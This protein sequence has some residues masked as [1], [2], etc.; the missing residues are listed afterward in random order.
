MNAGQDDACF[1]DTVKDEL[2]LMTTDRI[3]LVWMTQGRMV[4][5]LMTQDRMRCQYR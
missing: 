5:V 1:D 3:M 4:L 2:L